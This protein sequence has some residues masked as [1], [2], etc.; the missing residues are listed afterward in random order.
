MSVFSAILSGVTIGASIT[1]VALYPCTGSTIGTCSGTVIP[2]YGNVD[3]SLIKNLN[4]P[5]T[6]ITTGTTYV[7]LV[8]SGGGCT[9]N[10]ILPISNIPGASTPT[11]TP[12]IAGP[13]VTPTA[14]I[15][16]PTVTP[17]ATILAPSPSPSPTPAFKTIQ[18]A[19]P[20]TTA[21]DACGVSSGLTKYISS[22]YSNITNGIVVYNEAALTN[23]YLPNGDNTGGYWAIIFNGQTFAATFD[24]SDVGAISTKVDCATPLT[25]SAT[26]DASTY[27]EQPPGNV[28]TVTVTSSR[29]ARGMYLW[30]GKHA[31]TAGTDEFINYDQAMEIQNAT[32][33]T[34]E[35]VI[36]D[37]ETTETNQTFAVAIFTG[38]TSTKGGQVA[39]TGTFT[40]LDDSIT[41]QYRYILL[42][43]FLDATSGCTIPYSENNFKYYWDQEGT[44]Q[45]DGSDVL[46]GSTYCFKFVSP[47]NDPN[48]LLGKQLISDVSFND[49]P[50]DC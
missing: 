38:S 2:T 27:G 31:G 8:A 16:G 9:P 6:G 11:P 17:T 28:V 5:I 29:D 45:L 26:T 24:P 33:H 44:R 42:E 48:D 1:T 40:I 47:T 46:R 49:C 18:I 41:P 32:G 39:Q 23:K 36:D 34:F 22:A 12:T 20:Q 35:L 21:E 50:N 13:T 15:A 19:N 37:D 43:A 30:W 25:F 4:Y 3:V 10:L 14:T 7:N